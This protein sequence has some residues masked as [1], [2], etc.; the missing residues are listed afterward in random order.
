M[1][2]K[3]PQKQSQE[4]GQNKITETGP[5]D[6]RSVKEPR[7]EDQSVDLE[8]IRTFFEAD[9]FA[10]D[11]G[12]VIEWA[13]RGKAVCSMIVEPR[14]RNAGGM[15]QGGAVFTLADF[16]FAVASNAGQPLTVSL[17]N[18]ITFLKAA[19]G[20]KLTAEAVCVS[21]GKSTCFYRVSVM[22]DMGTFVAEMT[23]NGYIRG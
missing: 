20:N 17:S 5:S 3:R 22:D 23:V 19:K 14:H 6:R 12:A 21:S 13:E 9:R 1:E 8:Q 10:M 15:V 7:A 2:Q 16:A 4:Q 11:A 18:Q